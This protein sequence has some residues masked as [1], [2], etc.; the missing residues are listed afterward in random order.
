MVGR[1]LLP[2]LAA[3]CSVAALQLLTLL[4]S[5]TETVMVGE[6]V[7]QGVAVAHPAVDQVHRVPVLAV[8][9]VGVA[10]EGRGAPTDVVAHAVHVGDGAVLAPLVVQA[11]HR[12]P[13]FGRRFL[14]VERAPG[15]ADAGHH[16][17]QQ[18]RRGR[19]NHDPDQDSHAFHLR[20]YNLVL[21]GA[22]VLVGRGPA[23]E[24]VDAL[25]HGGAV[26]S[27]VPVPK[28]VEV[29]G[30]VLGAQDSFCMLV[31]RQLKVRHP[32]FLCVRLFIIKAIRLNRSQIS[33]HLCF[34]IACTSVVSSTI[35]SSFC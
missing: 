6:R 15:A 32:G 5:S 8:V 30:T 11:V 13:V 28:A 19:T 17:Q 14:L 33:S 22:A 25:L 20:L 16:G 23:T 18:H 21:L 9:V 7:G 27:I 26:E 35:S 1:G 2:R 24:Y 29:P 10:G 4:Y 12:P 31:L 3:Q 34:T